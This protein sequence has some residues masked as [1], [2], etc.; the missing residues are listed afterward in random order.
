MPRPYPISIKV[1]GATRKGEWLLLQGCKVYV[2]SAWGNETVDGY[3]ENLQQLAERTLERLVRADDQK[4]ADWK[5]YQE[6][7]TAKLLKPH[8]RRR[9]SDDGPQA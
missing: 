1:D 6:R 9:P 8:R 5:A 7:E 4:R 3:G 2:R